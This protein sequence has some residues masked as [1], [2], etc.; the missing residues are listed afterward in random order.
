MNRKFLFSLLAILV[1]T[2][3]LFSG[4]TFVNAQVTDTD[5]DGVPDAQEAPGDSDGDGIP[6]VEDPDDDG[7]GIPTILEGTGDYDEDGTPNYLDEDS[8]NDGK[9]DAEEGIN[10]V[11]QDYRPNFIDAHDDSACSDEL[12]LMDSDGDSLSDA[13]EMGPDCEPLDTDGDGIPNHEDDDDD[14]DGILTIDEIIKITHEVVIGE[15]VFH[16]PIFGYIHLDTIE[17]SEWVNFNDVDGDGIPN[18]LDTDSDGDGI[19]DAEEGQEDGDSDGVPNFLDSDDQDGPAADPDGD[20]LNN[21]LE[22]A[23]GSNPYMP[24]TDG[25]GVCD[26]DEVNVGQ[27]FDADGD[28]IPNVLDTDDDGDGIPTA[29][30]GGV[31]SDGDGIPNYLDTDSDGDGKSDA[32]EGLGDD[33]CDGIPNY[34]D[35]DETDGPCYDPCLFLFPPN[36]A[37]MQWWCHNCLFFD[38]QGV[39]SNH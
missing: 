6:D 3:L 23:L 12:F 1:A 35:P 7:D 22:E 13:A 26:G 17:T 19:P 27:S 5:G 37:W 10:D 8:D 33:D 11:D 25:D 14:G 16:V 38:G 32:E 18:Y 21:H 24:D 29:D 20:G 4:Y 2:L 30:E 39:I 34:V 31:D 36:N 15:R 9:S 28:G